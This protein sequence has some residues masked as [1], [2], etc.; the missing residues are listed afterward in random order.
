MPAVVC[1]GV[2][3]PL[4]PLAAG[5]DVDFVP[6]CGVP[7]PADADVAIVPPVVI[8]AGVVDAVPAVGVVPCPAASEGSPLGAVVDESPLQPTTKPQYV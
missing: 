1:G 5:V 2:D 3:P 7:V 4:P 6:A 8:V